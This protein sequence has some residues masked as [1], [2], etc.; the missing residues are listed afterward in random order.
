ML[1]T[2]ATPEEGHQAQALAGHGL[3]AGGS[4][5][6]SLSRVVEGEIIPRL[7][8]AHRLAPDT[9]ACARAGGLLA[10]GLSPGPRA[11][12][13]DRVASDS[14]EGDA[15]SL[16]RHV[17]AYLSL[18]VPVETLLV[19]LLAP[20]ARR[21]GEWWEED[22]CDFVD[23]TMGLW[24]LQEVMHEIAAGLPGAPSVAPGAQAALFAVMPRDTHVFGAVMAET[25][26]RRAGWRTATELEGSAGQLEASVAD[27]WFDLAGLTVSTEEGL[28]ELPALIERLR[29]AS[30]NPDLA[31]MVG[32]WLFVRSP[33]LVHAVGADATA[34]DARDAVRVAERLLRRPPLPDGRAAAAS[35]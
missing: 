17:E 10:A 27:S 3:A 7:L 13:I 22:R 8:V 20:A 24:R 34:A 23:V 16:L 35:A 18:G 30:R 32:G 11:A 14:I 12:D 5:D 21:L 33:G 1:R 28:A 19:E 25:C 6:D 4:A 2:G 9:R 31:I 29:R 15:W 26:F